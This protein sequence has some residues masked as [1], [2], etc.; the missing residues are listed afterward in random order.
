MSETLFRPGENCCAAVRAPRVGFLIDGEAYFDAFV[1][2]CER[3]ERLIVILA[4]DFD[5]RT[6][7]RYDSQGRPLETLGP[8]LNKLCERNRKLRVRILDWDFPVVFGADR[9]YSPIFGLNWEPHR[10]IQFRFDDT[11]PLAGSHHQKIVA[12]DDKLAFVGGLDLTNKR[13]DSP[14]HAPDDPRRAFEDEPY[15]PFHDVMVAVDGP[16]ATALANVARERWHA[17]TNRR[18]PTV[19]RT[20][21]DPWPPEIPVA[22]RDAS[23]AVACTLPPAPGRE[24]IHQVE[25]LY[26]D[27]IAK[28][29]RSIYIENQYFTSDRIGRALEK[30]LA[31]PDGPEIILVTRLLSHGWLEENTMSVLRTRLVRMLRAADAHG[32][33][34][35]YYPHVE[36]LCEGT[37]LDLH[38]KV[39]IVD[40]EWL[41]AGSSNLSNRSMGVDTEADLTIESEGRP[42]VRAAIRRFRDRLI[43]EHAGVP[44]E[45]LAP[46][47]EASP[48]IA[49]AVEQVS[50][51][52]RRLMELEAP[53]LSEAVIAAAAIGDME[54]PISIDGLVQGLAHDEPPLVEHAPPG[55]ALAIGTVLAVVAALAFA[56]RYTPLSGAVTPERVIDAATLLA[57]YWWAPLAIILAYTPAC[58]VMFPRPLITMAAVIV[59]GPVEGLAYAMLGVVLAGLAGYAIGRLVH[60]DTVRRLAGPRLHRLTA[61]LQ[62]RGLLAVTLIR[63]VP[64]APYAVV[65]IVMGAMR[66]RLTHFVLGTFFGM[67]PGA[68]AAAVLSDQAAELLRDPARVNGALVVGAVAAFAALAWGGQRLLRRLEPRRR[69]AGAGGLVD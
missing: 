2:A 45:R 39:M 21:G 4:W 27:M 43:A 44:V 10:H 52:P 1:R 54:K 40:D 28:A 50:R 8:F 19:R 24:G 22:M 3:A 48:S 17:A 12:I 25:S 15:P 37:C 5:S 38:S 23:V 66:I 31:E 41:R 30:R 14:A 34:K 69:L 18:L 49:A 53:E 36:G 61:V 42:E 58:L 57:R 55:R 51:G 29:R 56:W 63:F 35:A 64:V 26:L 62:R 59:F 67:L 32:R 33:F 7:L 11:H 65:N 68:I 9:E 60:R 13:W 16:A 6:V 46:V 47:L 20:S